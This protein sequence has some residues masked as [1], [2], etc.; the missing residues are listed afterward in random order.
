MWIHIVGIGFFGLHGLS[1]CEFEDCLSVL[2]CVHNVDMKTFDLHELISY[3]S[4]AFLSLRMWIHNEDMGTF[5]LHVHP[6][7]VCLILHLTKI[8]YH[9]LSMKVSELLELYSYL[10]IVL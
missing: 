3:V 8:S 4:E 5:G 10:R 2:L 9:I 6:F 7:C 1:L